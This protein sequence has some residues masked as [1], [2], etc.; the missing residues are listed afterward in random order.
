MKKVT[1]SAN[2]AHL[3]SFV[4]MKHLQQFQ[5]MAL[6]SGA[7]T[8][9]MGQPALLLK[10]IV[11]VISA[12]RKTTVSQVMTRPVKSTAAKPAGAFALGK[13]K[14]GQVVGSKR[15][16]SCGLQVH[17]RPS[18]ARQALSTMPKVQYF[19]LAHSLFKH[20]ERATCFYEI[21]NSCIDS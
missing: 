1:Q 2:F 15:V 14:K 5:A 20:N 16:F 19:F 13:K 9:P 8:A 18:N 12:R 7:S 4:F 6:V 11:P 10:T 17:L 3:D 21:A